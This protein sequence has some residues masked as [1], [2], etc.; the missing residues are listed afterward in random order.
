MQHLLALEAEALARVPGTCSSEDRKRPLMTRPIVRLAENT[1]AHTT[2]RQEGMRLSSARKILVGDPLPNYCVHE[3]VKL[4]Q[5]VTLHVAV[6][7]PEGELIHVT[8]HMLRAR[9][10]GR[11]HTPRASGR[12]GSSPCC[13]GPPGRARPPRDRCLHKPRG[14]GEGRTTPISG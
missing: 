8:G 5:R 10:N 2:L 11:R 12:R 4:L 7:Q 1:A 6:I 9:T 13:L 3:T 14:A